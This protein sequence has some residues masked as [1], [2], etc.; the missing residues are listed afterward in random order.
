MPTEIDAFMCTPDQ[1]KALKNAGLVGHFE[2]N[3][4]D[5]NLFFDPM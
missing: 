3:D 5:D 1:N 2:L 4:Q